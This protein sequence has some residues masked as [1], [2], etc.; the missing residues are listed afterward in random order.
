LNFGTFELLPLGLPTLQ[1]FEEVSERSFE[2]DETI[3]VAALESA[4]SQMISHDERLSFYIAATKL[5]RAIGDD[6]DQPSVRGEI[7]P[8]VRSTI[9]S[10][11]SRL[12]K[13]FPSWKLQ[14]WSMSWAGIGWFKMSLKSLATFLSFSPAGLGPR[15]TSLYTEGNRGSAPTMLPRIS[16]YTAALAP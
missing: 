6:L 12:V 2:G 4:H 9:P 13:G 15:S 3:L 16:P 1:V 5:R 14:S 11:L 7:D 10:N 8:R